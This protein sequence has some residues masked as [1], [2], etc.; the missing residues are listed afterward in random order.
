MTDAQFTAWQTKAWEI[1][2]M[3]M[4]RK[5]W[6]HDEVQFEARLLAYLG[7]TPKSTEQEMK[8]AYYPVPRSGTTKR[9]TRLD[10]LHVI[11]TYQN[12]CNHASIEIF[13]MNE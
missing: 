1:F 12:A 11:L 5:G 6:T 7:F 10:R 4:R 8:E 2:Y 9:L 13:E 3:F